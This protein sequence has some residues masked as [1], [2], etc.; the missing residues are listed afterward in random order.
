M[1]KI[2]IRPTSEGLLVPII[3]GG[4]LP[5]EG[6]EVERTNYWNRRLNDGDVELID[7]PSRRRTSAPPATAKPDGQEG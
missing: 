2:R 3:G 1:S 4:Y 5:A 6:A 7:K